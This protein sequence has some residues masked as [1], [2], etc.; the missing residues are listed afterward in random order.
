VT[1]RRLTR[2]V[3]VAALGALL[4]GCGTFEEDP[5]ATVNGRDIS[6]SELHDELDAIEHN[7]GYRTLLEQ[8]LSQDSAGDGHGT[9]A[10][11]FVS[12]LLSDKVYFTLI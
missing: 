5:A 6:D 8:Q 3:A 1:T 2:L 7:D 10:T 11:P 12:G 4:A 9:F